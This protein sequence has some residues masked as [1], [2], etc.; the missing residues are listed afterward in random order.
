MAEE[1][2]TAE[3]ADVSEQS[4]IRLEKLNRLVRETHRAISGGEEEISI[5]Y[6]ATIPEDAIP[7]ALAR[8]RQRE[9]AEGG[10]TA[11]PHRD[12]LE[13]RLNGKDIRV[14]ASQ[15]Q[16]RTLMLAV[17]TACLDI[18]R[19]STGHTP[20]LLLDDVFSELDR[21]R[22][23][24]LLKT[25]EGIQTFITTADDADARL[26]SRARLFYVENGKVRE[27]KKKTK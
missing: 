1:I 20:V 8:Y 7:E 11:G 14:F 19:E 5:E 17:K 13:I 2:R 24:N 18:L 15:G 4:R 6:K 12:D 27:M 9:L 3:Q 25:L 21:T 26:L 10:C 23:Q 16:L 22:K